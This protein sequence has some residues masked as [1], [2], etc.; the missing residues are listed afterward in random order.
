MKG[1]RCFDFVMSVIAVLLLMPTFLLIAALIKATSKGPI[2]F[3][4]R[5]IGKNN[6]E[7]IIYKFR[8]M[9][10][11]APD[12]P[13]HLLENSCDYTTSLGNILRKTSLDELP[14]LINIIKGDMSIVGPRPALYNQYDLIELR[15]KQDIHKIIPGLTGWAQINGRDEV[16]LEEKVNLDNE[17]KERRSF[18]FDLKIIFLTVTKVISREG[19]A[20]GT[21][22]AAAEEEARSERTL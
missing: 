4:Q 18:I 6:K 2:L 22:R 3:K 14:Q 11:E 5:R 1:K 9:V 7:F 21:T 12:L 17:Y 19:L 8:T 16:S 15:T 20:Q 10:T 13:T